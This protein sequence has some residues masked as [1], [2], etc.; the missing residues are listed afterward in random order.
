MN[1]EKL[2]KYPIIKFLLTPSYIVVTILVRAS[3]SFK[4]FAGSDHSS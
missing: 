4:D 2:L 1:N 3:G